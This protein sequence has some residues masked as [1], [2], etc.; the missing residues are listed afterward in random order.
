M[1]TSGSVTGRQRARRQAVTPRTSGGA[2]SARFCRQLRRRTPAWESSWRCPRSC[3]TGMPLPPLRRCRKAAP[4]KC[5]LR[6][7]VGDG[8]MLDVTDVPPEP[9]PLTR[10]SRAL[11]RAAAG[12][13]TLPVPAMPLQPLVTVAVVALSGLLTITAFAGAPMVALAVALAAGVIA[14]GW[15]GLL[16]LPSPGGTTLVLA[17]G[18]AGAIGTALVTLDDP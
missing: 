3:R 6:L 16:G 1:S 5:C 2:T 7:P 8:R 11:A 13:V 17:V 12:P 14:W 4:W 18:S 15:P 10:V 9:P